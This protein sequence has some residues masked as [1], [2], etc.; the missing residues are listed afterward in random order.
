MSQDC[1]RRGAGF[2]SITLDGK[3]HRDVTGSISGEFQ[4]SS[5]HCFVWEEVSHT[6]R[7]HTSSSRLTVLLQLCSLVLKLDVVGEL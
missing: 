2:I 5:S 7:T 6:H 1:G 4:R 3:P